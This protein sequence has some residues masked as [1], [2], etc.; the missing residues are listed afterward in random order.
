M[1]AGQPPPARQQPISS[2]NIS[3]S[4]ARAIFRAVESQGY[5]PDH[6]AAQ[7]GVDRA[8]LELER[9]MSA[10]VFGRLY[11]RAMV[12]LNDES[13]GIVCGDRVVNGTFRMMCLCVIHRPTLQTIV[14]R[15]AEFFDVCSG[16]V[17]K[18]QVIAGSQSVAVAF[19]TVRDETDRTVEDIL[20]SEGAVKVR[21]TLYLWHSLL[22]WFAGKNLPLIGV[23]FSFEAPLKGAQWEQMFRCPVSFNCPQS[24]LRFEPGVM[25]LANVQTEQSLSLFLKT[26][27]YRLIVPAYHDQRLSDRVVALFGEDFSKRL[28]GAA[29]VSQALN[30]SVSTL[31]RQLLEEGTSFQQLKDECRRAAALQYLAS[32]ELS[33]PE[34]AGLLGFDEVSAFYRAFRRWTGETPSQ[35]RHSLENQSR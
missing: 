25:Q 20:Q 24:Q 32:S 11:Q 31:R 30:M 18:P 28:P 14:Q 16:V 29:H 12:L 10:V 5:D 15:A 1:I 17:V 35:F 4:Y 27:P 3:T 22:S 34:V 8:A 13:L 19:A 26:A 9:E 6:F 33:F 21:T 23:D 7:E 2:G